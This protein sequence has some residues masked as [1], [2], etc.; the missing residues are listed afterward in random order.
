MIAKKCQ[1]QE[2]VQWNAI[3]LMLWLTEGLREHLG[4]TANLAQPDPSV[5]HKDIPI[6]SICKKEDH[7]KS[8]D[9]CTPYYSSCD[10]EESREERR[11]ELRER[12]AKRLRS[13]KFWQSP[14][15]DTY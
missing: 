14:Y 8:R 12:H 5:C 10:L 9:W 6:P 11:E 2:A 3:H 1:C 15:D 7:I 4:K 13:Q